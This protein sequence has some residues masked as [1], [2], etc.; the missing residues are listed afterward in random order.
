MSRLRVAIIGYGAVADI[1][2]GCLKER[3]DIELVAVVGP[4]REPALDFAARHRIAQTFA[5]IPE[6]FESIHPDA[7]IIASP[8]DLHLLH[9]EQ[10]IA[11][12]IHALVEFPFVAAPDRLSALF[13]QAR[14]RGLFLA[15]AHTSRFIWSFC[16]AQTILAS[17]TLGRVR[18]VHYIRFMN[19][20]ARTGVG[21]QKRT[22][23]DDVLLHHAGHALD[24]FLSWF[25]KEVKLIHAV[26]PQTPEGRRNVGLMLIGPEGYPITA[27]LSYDA[28]VHSLQADVIAENGTI[29]IDGFAAL[30]VNQ[31]DHASHRPVHDE[32]AY[33]AA[34]RQQD[35]RFVQAI[36]GEAAFP[37][38]AEATLTLNAMLAQAESLCPQ[39]TASKSH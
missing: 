33:H 20:P 6:A 31:M 17:R 24:V 13:Q 15:T 10:A 16:E 8:S 36:Q 39:N 18:T 26:A 37:V 38:P 22:W 29:H 1:H 35:H 25:G 5:A 2:A 4:R 21:G 30:R 19:R 3:S 34:I 12:G 14:A 7:A 23:T 28:N 11:A 27:A 32:A 9:A